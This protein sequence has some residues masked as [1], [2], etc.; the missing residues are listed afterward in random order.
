M[1]GVVQLPRAGG[2]KYWLSQV[3]LFAIGAISSASLVGVTIARAGSAVDMPWKIRWL[4]VALVAITLAAADLN[5][6]GMHTPSLAR[7][8]KKSWRQKF[9]WAPAILFWGVDLGLGFSTIRA[10]SGFWAGAV[11]AFAAGNLGGTA[12]VTT[13]YGFGLTL[14]IIAAT[15]L[16]SR[17]GPTGNV[18]D[19]GIAAISLA[20][21]LR[22]AMGWILG[23]WGVS[24]LA[25]SLAVR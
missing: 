13:S 24:L 20:G 5:L 8:T 12:A 11:A 6:A 25:L 1:L 9:G 17:I 15:L 16:L 14:G 21:G 3:I 23:L 2:L 18:I 7:Q 4:I 19:G 10:T 22:R